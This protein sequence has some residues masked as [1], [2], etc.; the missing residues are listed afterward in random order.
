MP[1]RRCARSEAKFRGLYESVLEGVYQF[2]PDGKVL[3]VNPAFVRLLGYSSAEE[4]YALPGVGALYCGFRAARQLRAGT[5]AGRRGAHGRDRC[6]AGA[7]ARNWWCSRARAW[8]A[9]SSSG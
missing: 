6:C 8:C 1:P 4:V 2:S 3:A 5:G 9:T 7:T